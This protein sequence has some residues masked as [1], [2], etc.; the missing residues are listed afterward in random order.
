MTNVSTSASRTKPLIIGRAWDNGE[1]RTSATGVPQPRIKVRLSNNL[2]FPITFT[3]GTE[4]ALWP[5]TLEKRAGRQDP[6]YSVSVQLPADIV[7]A[8]IA[9]QK[10]ASGR[11]GAQVA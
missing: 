3:P 2:G 8:E 11:G 1:A 10:A 6:D 9:R 7:D 5:N 4:I